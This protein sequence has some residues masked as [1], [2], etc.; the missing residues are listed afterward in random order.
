MILLEI[1]KT[2]I[3]IIK[4]IFLKSY[5]KKSSQNNI[6]PRLVL[7]LYARIYNVDANILIFIGWAFYKSFLNIDMQES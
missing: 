6:F 2:F 3:I 1:D 7:T 5:L 4:E